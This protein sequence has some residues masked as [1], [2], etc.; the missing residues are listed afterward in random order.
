[1]K[2]NPTSHYKTIRRNQLGSSIA[3]FAPALFV[4][5]LLIFF[6]ILDILG[7]C[8]N[9]GVVALLNYNQ[10]REAA[11]LPYDKA[12]DPSG[13]VK[14]EIP[15][16]WLRTGL[17][18]FVKVKGNPTTTISYRDGQSNGDSTTDKIVIVNTTV[19]CDP[20]ILLPI[21]VAKVPGLNAPMTLSPTSE[22][23][24]ENP[25]NALP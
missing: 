14:K 4:L 6:P 7:I 25:D 17:G 10:V 12:N 22:R 3:E 16:A 18:T 20:L 21:P 1:M 19:V 8:F 13:A 11:L 24:M 23:P 2:A 9:Y 5:L 15:D